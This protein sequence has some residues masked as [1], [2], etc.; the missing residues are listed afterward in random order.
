MQL[1]GDQT[2]YSTQNSA[3]G[4][5][6]LTSACHVHVAYNSSIMLINVLIL[7][8]HDQVGS[9]PVGLSSLRSVKRSQYGLQYCTLMAVMLT[10]ACSGRGCGTSVRYSECCIID[11]PAMSST[12]HRSNKT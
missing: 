6:G 12:K 8:N 3:I 4:T 10:S 11:I 2:C 5:C 7:G 1:V 9:W